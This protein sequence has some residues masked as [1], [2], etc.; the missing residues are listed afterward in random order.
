MKRVYPIALI[1]FFTLTILLGLY[2][3]QYPTKLNKLN[4]E[5]ELQKFEEINDIKV[6]KVAVIDN[7]ILALYTFNN[8][9]GYGTFTRD[10]MV[11]VYLLHLIK[12]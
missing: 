8:G 12:T 4:L 6:Q 3:I 7:K 11:D 2:F 10:L 9:I 5:L 1:I